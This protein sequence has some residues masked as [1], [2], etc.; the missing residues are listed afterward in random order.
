METLL[1][2]TGTTTPGNGELKLLN[3]SNY[4]TVQNYDSTAS[5][6]LDKTSSILFETNE[7]MK[8]Y[9]SANCVKTDSLVPEGNGG[10]GI[11]SFI[12]LLLLIASVV[13]LMMPRSNTGNNSFG[14]AKSSFTF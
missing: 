2:P 4:K 12:L 14:L 8:N 10:A 6:Q 1:A 3:P 11:I 9:L 7:N 5:P 13:Y